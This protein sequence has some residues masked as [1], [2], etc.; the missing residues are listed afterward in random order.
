MTQAS[1]SAD[2]DTHSSASAGPC[3][4]S[5]LAALE[6]RLQSGKSR[7]GQEEG[8]VTEDD[9]GAP[10]PQP[11]GF[12][13]LSSGPLLCPSQTLGQCSVVSALL[14]Q[15]TDFGMRPEFPSWLCTSSCVTWAKFLALSEFQ[16]PLCKMEM[17]LKHAKYV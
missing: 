17:T 5:S 14:M 4:L 9:L 15:E 16:C 13:P 7:V 3:L 1:G 8:S 12:F 10:L 11:L 2:T 6:R